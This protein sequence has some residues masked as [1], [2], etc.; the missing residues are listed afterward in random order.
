MDEADL[1][2]RQI[3]INIGEKMYKKFIR[4]FK[5]LAKNGLEASKDS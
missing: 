5:A 2:V 1:D 3:K 4:F